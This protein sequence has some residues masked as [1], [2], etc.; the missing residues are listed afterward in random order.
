MSE[1]LR[2]VV[3]DVDGTLVNSQ[4]HIL[5]SMRQAFSDLGLPV[6]NDQEIM[7]GIGLSLPQLMARLVPDATPDL[8]HALAARYKELSFARHSAVGSDAESPFYPGMR[9]V[10][11]ELR[12][13]DFT[14]MATATGKSRRGLNRMIAHHG[15]DGYFQST[16]V[17]DDHPS[18]PHPSMVHRAMSE[19]GVAAENAVMVGDTSYD[20]AMG[21]AAGMA[22]IGVSWGYHPASHLE[23]NSIVHS[24]EGLMIA[25]TTW[26][27]RLA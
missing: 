11:D 16:Q 3:F 12:G 2:L 22:T 14:L 19:T 25:L 18:K 20:M 5:V 26:I 6:P 8:H 21:H 23:A 24:A 7:H 15:L 4:A 10:L 27:E 13:D 1:P 17:A 9:E